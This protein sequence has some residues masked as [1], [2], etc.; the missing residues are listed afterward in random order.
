MQ[1]ALDI[2]GL[3]GCVALVGSVSPGPEVRFEPNSFVRN[4]SRVVGSH[5]YRVDDL[6]EAVDFL[7][8]T[9]MQ[10]RFAELV[11]ASYPLAEI[12]AAVNEART[13]AAP[14]IAVHLT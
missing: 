12:D 2:V 9:P 6:V 5:N 10:D 1:S 4:L 7:V 3:N 13:G 14:R 11:P 8:R